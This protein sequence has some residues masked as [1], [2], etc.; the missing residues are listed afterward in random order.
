MNEYV[1]ID[2]FMYYKVKVFHTID[3]D[4]IEILSFSLTF[5]SGKKKAEYTKH[6]MSDVLNRK[7]T[8][9]LTSF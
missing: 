6:F 1:L 7:S 5:H 2:E 3:P 8:I 9:L 4:L